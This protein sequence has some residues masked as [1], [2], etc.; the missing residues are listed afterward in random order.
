MSG[1]VRDPHIWPQVV[2][3]TRNFFVPLRTEMEL[4]ERKESN[5]REQGPTNQAGR[6]PPNFCNEPQLQKHPKGIIKNSF[7]F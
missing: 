2:L 6:P 5:N 3:P 7:E 1:S 4:E